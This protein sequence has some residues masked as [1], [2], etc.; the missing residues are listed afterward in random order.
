MILS[1]RI[2]RHVFPARKMYDIADQTS[3]MRVYTIRTSRVE[4]AFHPQATR[5]RQLARIVIRPKFCG[6]E[7][8]LSVW[9]GSMWGFDCSA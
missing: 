8:V 1:V 5:A 7:C 4:H 6:F 3:T 9:R 2:E